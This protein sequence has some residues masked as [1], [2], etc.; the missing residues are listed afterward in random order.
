M[1]GNSRVIVK[2]CPEYNYESIVAAVRAALVELRIA[3]ELPRKGTVF[4]KINNL[5]TVPPERVVTTHPLVLKAVIAEVQKVTKDIVVGDDVNEMLD[6]NEAFSLSGFKAVCAEMN[7]RLVN[8]KNAERTHAK[9]RDGVRVRSIITSRIVTDAAYVINLP[10]MKTHQLTLFTGAIKNMYGIMPF[11]QKVSLHKNNASIQDFKEICVDVFSVRRPDLTVMDA[12]IGM[13]GEG[14]SS[15]KPRKIGYVFVSKDG[16]SIDALCEYMI[17]LE[18]KYGL[19]SRL[20]EKRGL[21]IA[22]LDR[23]D[24]GDI[25]KSSLRLKGFVLPKSTMSQRTMPHWLLGF[26]FGLVAPKPVIDHAT[27]KRCEAC[28]KICPKNTIEM[29]D[30]KVVIHYKDCIRCF[31]CQELCSFKAIS[32]EQS[33]VG[34][35]LLWMNSMASR[36]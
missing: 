11:G 25:E 30:E 1:E 35:F 36:K 17:G 18:E 16:V 12:V 27:C 22:A 3:A 33:I 32:A 19:V 26:I 14:P 2:K 15:G 8:L 4:I 5:L 23:I 21:G 13:E 28:I 31:C 24:T 29:I 7:V 20:A 9:V 34:K 6:N 10:K